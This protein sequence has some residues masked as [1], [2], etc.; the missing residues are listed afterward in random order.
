MV[1]TNRTTRH[2]RIPPHPVRRRREWRVTVMA[3]LYAK[4]YSRK[5]LLKFFPLIRPAGFYTRGF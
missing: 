4:P 1:Q 3:P 5:E 2:H